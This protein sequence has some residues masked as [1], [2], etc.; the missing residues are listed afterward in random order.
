MKTFRFATPQGRKQVAFSTGYSRR[1]ALVDFLASLQ[2]GKTETIVKDAIISA[3]GFHG[4]RHETEA[5]AY[6]QL[7]NEKDK[8]EFIYRA[9]LAYLPVLSKKLTAEAD[10]IKKFLRTAKNLA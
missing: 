1:Q 4:D 2:A 8:T 5:H 6:A 9:V 10:E 7:Q 3:Y